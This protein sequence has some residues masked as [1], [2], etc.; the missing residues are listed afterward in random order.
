MEPVRPLHDIF[1]GLASDPAAQRGGA[2]EPGDALR[3]GG[4]GELPDAL[5]AEAIVSYAGTAPAEVA[6]HLAP[7][8]TGHGPVRYE[9]SAGLDVT[10]G[11][12]LLATVPPPEPATEDSAAE[13]PFDLAFG[14]GTGDGEPVEAVGFDPVT[15]TEDVLV[16]LEAGS[17]PGLPEPDPDTDP[18]DLFPMP[19][20]PEPDEPGEEQAGE[21]GGG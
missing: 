11:L 14:E 18:V 3:A 21:G 15:G 12:D 9:D 13:D 10:H 5:V 2:A 6:E 4:H 8:V 17:D 7:F 20:P 1:A 16:G 19:G